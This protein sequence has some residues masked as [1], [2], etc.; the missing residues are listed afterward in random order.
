MINFFSMGNYSTTK[1]LRNRVNNID[2]VMNK[3]VNKKS[4]NYKLWIKNSLNYLN[5]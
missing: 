2:F 4:N 5:F 3:Y 1:I